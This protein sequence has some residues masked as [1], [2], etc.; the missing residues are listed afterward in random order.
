MGTFRGQGKMYG[1]RRV[2][3]DICFPSR[4]PA[5]PENRRGRTR[6]R[7]ESSVIQR[8]RRFI[9]II[10]YTRTPYQRVSN[11][12]KGRENKRRWRRASRTTGRDFPVFRFNGSG[13]DHPHFSPVVTARRSPSVSN[14]Y[15]QIY[16]ACLSVLIFL[17]VTPVHNKGTYN[18]FVFVVFRFRV[19][20]ITHSRPTVLSKSAFRPQISAAVRVYQNVASDEFADCTS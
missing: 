2:F 7:F 11:G 5:L 6:P 17:F 1:E 9:V 18:V 4:H 8:R 12:T 20:H 3:S 14:G 10:V 15:R 13:F 19:S 16:R